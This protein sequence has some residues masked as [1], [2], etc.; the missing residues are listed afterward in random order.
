MTTTLPWISLLYRWPPPD[1]V[2]REVEE[3]AR[4]DMEAH[5]GDAFAFDPILVIPMIDHDGDEYLRIRV[6]YDGDPE[7]MDSVLAHRLTMRIEPKLREMGFMQPPSSSFVPKSEWEEI[8]RERA[9]ASPYSTTS[10]SAASAPEC[11]ADAPPSAK[12]RQERSATMTTTLPWIS[13]LYRWPP[14][15]D[16]LREVGEIVRN[17][18]EGH[19]GDAFVFDP[20][21]VIPKIDHDEVE[22]LHIYIVFDGDFDLLETRWTGRLYSRMRSRLLEMG[23][24]SYTS[25]SYVEKSEWEYLGERILKRAETKVI[26]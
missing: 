1:E 3:L 2:L 23:I 9:E 25:E 11:G 6:I 20:I 26:L 12:P 22:Y 17:D 10:A 7:M 14:S 15:D 16:V 5:F 21:V 13:L 18:L 8:R 4:E 24:M 19:F